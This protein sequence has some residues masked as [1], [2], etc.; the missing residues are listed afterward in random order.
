MKQRRKQ[1]YYQYGSNTI[2]I[3]YVT[4][5]EEF[6]T[7]I[8]ER[9]NVYCIIPDACID[10]MLNSNAKAHL[11]QHSFVQWPKQYQQPIKKV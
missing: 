8:R 9:S 11:I 2:Y 10:K 7:W 4:N 1:Y 6:L 5:Y 3:A